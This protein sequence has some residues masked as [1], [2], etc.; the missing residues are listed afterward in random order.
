MVLVALYKTSGRLATRHGNKDCNSED[1]DRNNAIVVKQ[2]FVSP[3]EPQWTMGAK[4]R[5]G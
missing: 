2:A 4:Q 5:T 3:S 1:N